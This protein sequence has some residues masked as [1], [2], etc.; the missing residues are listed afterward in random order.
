MPD[1]A[2]RPRPTRSVKRLHER[3]GKARLD[4]CGV[5]DVT[6]IVPSLGALEKL[7]T[8]GKLEGPGLEI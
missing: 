8:K 4:Y 5:L 7:P 2:I 3:D 1:T 6:L